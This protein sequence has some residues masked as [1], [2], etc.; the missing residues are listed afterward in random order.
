MLHATAAQQCWAVRVR[1]LNM[2]S[3]TFS[4]TF[5]VFKLYCLKST[6]TIFGCTHRSRRAWAISPICWA[7]AAGKRESTPGKYGGHNRFDTLLPRS[8]QCEPM[9]QFISSI[10]R[11]SV[12]NNVQNTGCALLDVSE[13]S[14]LRWR[15]W[16]IWHIYVKDSGRKEEDRQRFEALI[17]FLFFS[18][19]K[20][21]WRR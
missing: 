10:R 20:L 16:H 12:D 15:V 9:P 4:L 18:G 14:R 6:K 11:L 8:R 5:S 3:S 1:W 13:Q 21:A 17:S 7:T 19:G 2:V